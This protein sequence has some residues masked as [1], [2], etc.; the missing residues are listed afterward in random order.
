MNSNNGDL[1]MAM[2][3]IAEAIKANNLSLTQNRYKFAAY[4]STAMSKVDSTINQIIFNSVEFDTMDAYDPVTGLFTVPVTGYWRIEARAHVAGG[5]GAAWLWGS[6]LDL[7]DGSD[8]LDTDGLYVYDQGRYTSKRLRVG[9]LY[10]LS[11]GQ[12]ISALV[13]ADT[14]NGTNYSVSA[15]KRY[16]RFSAQLVTQV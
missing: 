8:Y 13:S 12:E 11:E 16:T 10:Y 15:G 3:G 5:T 7:Y 14:N 6:Q 4:L 1:V 9:D 2:Q